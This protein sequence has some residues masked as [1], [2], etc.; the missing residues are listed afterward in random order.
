[1]ARRVSRRA[2]A[3]GGL[4]ALGVLLLL[5]LAAVWTFE[6]PGPK[7]REGAV[8]TVVLAKGSGVRQI[9]AALKDAGV[10]T[11]PGLF[12]LG[13][14]VT[15]AAAHLKAGEYEI[16]SGA[17]MASILGDLRA[18]RVVRHLISVPEGWTSGMALDAV[19]ASDVLTGTA[20]EPPEGAILPDSYEVQRGE[21]RAAV[22]GKMEAAQARL[23]AELWAGRDP[24]LPI[25]T[26][27][28]AVTLASIVEKETGVA[29]ERPR[30]AGV[31]INRLRAG[32]ALQSDPTII[33]G[34]SKGRP[35]GRGIRQSELD[36]LTPYN[37][38]KVVGLPPT[39]IANPGRA[40]LMAVLH[41][42]KTDELYFVA[43]GTGGHAFAS[44]I[45]AHQAN[46]AKWR[47][48]EKQRAAGAVK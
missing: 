17:S 28:E 7:A 48:L 33:Y 26:P 14:R 29:A 11:S 13:A 46:V 47:A 42:M 21:D 44:T 12:S 39:P 18:G 43:N 1:M 30:V 10:I 15:G 9:G 35:L 31:F 6:G 4:I 8:T 45:E 16:A 27:Q 32:M 38:Y 19:N 2:A 41:P 20:T 24:G 22:I 5:A 36:A 3:G 34:I 23:L 37:S 25:A 40:A